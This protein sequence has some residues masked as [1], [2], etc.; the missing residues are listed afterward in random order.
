MRVFA[1]ALTLSVVLL[2]GLASAQAQAPATQK[3]A[4]PAAPAAQAP[5]PPPFQDGLKYAYVQLQRVAAESNEGKA[6]QARIKEFNEKKVDELSAKNKALQSAQKRLEDGGSVMSDAARTQLQT[7]IERQQRDIQ[8]ASEDAQQDF[9]NFQQQVQED[10][11]RKLNP[12]VD[13]VAKEKGVHFVFSATDAGLIWADPTMDLTSDVIRVFNGSSTSK[14]AAAAPAAAAPAP[15]AA[16]PA[17]P[18]T[19]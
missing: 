18:T 19:K 15:S 2:A 12:I 1:V 14:P 4:A 6:A 7:E 9:Q 5:A 16:K 17:P 10:F 8:R 11:N 3:P 13:K